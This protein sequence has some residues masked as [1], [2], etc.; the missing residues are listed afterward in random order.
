VPVQ[1]RHVHSNACGH[2]AGEKAA[3]RD[4]GHSARVPTCEIREPAG[5]SDQTMGTLHDE[6]SIAV[7]VVATIR[8]LIM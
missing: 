2:C 4:N 1:V 8:L 6:G 3:Q 7:N 5:Y